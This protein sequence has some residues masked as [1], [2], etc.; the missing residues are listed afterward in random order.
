ML[1]ILGAL[2]LIVSSVYYYLTYNF[3]Y[4]WKNNVPSAKAKILLGNLPNVLLRKEHLVYD[5]EKL[6]K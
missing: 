5:F 6:Y 3:D 4:W 2:V 1:F